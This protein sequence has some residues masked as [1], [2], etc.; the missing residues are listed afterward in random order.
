[1]VIIVQPVSLLLSPYYY[2]NNNNNNKFNLHIYTG[3]DLLSFEL[4][5]C[6]CVLT[7]VLAPEMAIS[8]NQSW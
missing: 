7:S 6:R 1:M 8:L 3:H 5:N 4:R 2:N